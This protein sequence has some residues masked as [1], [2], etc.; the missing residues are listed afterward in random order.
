MVEIP[1]LSVKDKILLLDEVA[2]SAR[3]SW[4]IYLAAHENFADWPLQERSDPAYLGYCNLKNLLSISLMTTCYSLV[5]T[6]RRAYSLHHAITDPS[7]SVSSE[8]RKYCQDCFDLRAKIS[9]YRNNVVAHVNSRKTQADWAHL[10][11]ISNGEIDNF[12]QNVRAAIEELS[13]HNLEHG[14]APCVS[15]PVQD[16]FRAFCRM[17]V[18][19]DNRRHVSLKTTSS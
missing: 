10:A 15:M 12:L 7:L 16:H 19:I 3:S 18:G 2:S 6:G 13:I 4:Q 5:E 8:A 11:G 17:S 9:K 1:M 14:F